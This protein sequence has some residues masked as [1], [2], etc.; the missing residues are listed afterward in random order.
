[1][2]RGWRYVHYATLVSKNWILHKNIKA[3]PESF[4]KKMSVLTDFEVTEY[5]NYLNF[6]VYRMIINHDLN[7]SVS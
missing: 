2:V 4:F 3:F 6:A 5:H 7:N 1:M